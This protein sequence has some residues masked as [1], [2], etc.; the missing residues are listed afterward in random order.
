LK[1]C[2]RIY[3]GIE[4]FLGSGRGIAAN[5]FIDR[6]L[7]FITVG[8]HAFQKIE[9]IATGFITID[10]FAGDIQSFHHGIVYKQKILL[11]FSVQCFKLCDNYGLD[12]ISNAYLTGFAIDLYQ[13]G[14][15]IQRDTGGLEL[16]WPDR[17]L[18]FRRI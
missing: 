12:V 17:N 16:K 11:H 9:L 15:I 5:N 3:H 13:K 18:A 1:L 2:H 10:A 4:Q 6:F 14:I 8:I 7:R